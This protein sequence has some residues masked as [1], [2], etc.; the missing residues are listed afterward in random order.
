MRRGPGSAARPG[1]PGS[2][3][4]RRSRALRWAGAPP[5]AA[6]SSSAGSGPTCS[7]RADC[8]RGRRPRRAGRGTTTL[9]DRLCYRTGT[10]PVKSMPLSGLDAALARGLEPAYVV[11]GE[12]SPL[13]EAARARIEA[14]VRPRLGPVAFNHRRFRAGEDGLAGIA[15]ARTLPMMAALRLVEIRDLHEGDDEFYQALCD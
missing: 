2:R 12:A 7:R 5:T 13:V 3:S 1:G 8:Q 15:A 14:A 11:V 4:P 9:H 10:G 6:G